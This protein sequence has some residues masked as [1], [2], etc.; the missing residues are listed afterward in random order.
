[1]TDHLIAP[2]GGTL[3]DL[4]VD[5]DRAAELKT[6]SRD[7]PSHDLTPRQLC[8]LELLLNG[9][10]S[11]LTGFMGRGDH[12]RVCSDMRLADGT[13]WPMPITLDV[14]E[15]LAS[16]LEPG[17]NLALRDPEGVMLAVLHVEDVWRP[18]REAEAAAVFGSTNPEHPGVAHLLEGDAAVVRRRHAVRPAAGDALRLPP[19]APHAPRAAHGVRQAGLDA[20]GGVPDAQPDAPRAPG[21][22][23]A[24]REGGGGEPAH[25]S[26]RGHDEAGRRG[27]LHARALLPGAAAPL[28]A[29]DGHALAAAAGHAHGRPARG[30]VA[31]DHPQEPRLHAPD[32]GPRPCRT[33]QRLGRQ[34]VLRAVRRPGAAARARGG[35]SASR[36][37]RSS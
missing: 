5:E 11:P 27:P 7:W 8:D 1:M 28:P 20:G 3:V 13:L 10:L 15:E 16:K 35:G 31:R 36:W 4:I 9:G 26:R 22:D 25:P 29:Q 32:R 18:D 23:A 21:A 12:E 2:H 30:R 24:R 37:C 17:S 34:R 14:A 19:A 6:A 33:G